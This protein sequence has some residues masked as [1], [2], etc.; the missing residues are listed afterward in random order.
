VTAPR[1]APPAPAGPAPRPQG[2][3]ARLLSRSLSGYLCG[4][5][6]GLLDRRR[7][8]RL[9][10]EAIGRAHARLALDAGSVPLSLGPG[11]WRP[12]P[13]AERL[14][15]ALRDALDVPAVVDLVL[16]G[17]Q[18]RGSVTGYSDVDAILVI[19]DEVAGRPEALRELR[20]RVL[21]AQRHVLGYQPM[22]HHGF[23]LATPSLLRAAGDA[24]ALPAEALAET[25]TL[26]G[27]RLPAAS[28][29]VTADE[30]RRRWQDFAPHLLA[31]RSWPRHPWSLHGAISM[32]ALAPALFAQAAGERGPKWRSFDV[33]RRRFGNAWAPY[34]TL[35]EV[36][37]R[38]PDVG[39][40]VLAPMLRLGANPW[41]AVDAWR[42]LPV[43]APQPARALLTTQTLRDLHA[44]VAMM[45][46]AVE[47]GRS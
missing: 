14:A 28:E 19:E 38:W 39:P 33:G 4:T 41:P 7:G 3:K 37:E 40:G 25:A 47:A 29:P 30:A 32:F 46:A 1:S 6:S 17:S 21:R 42:R 31:L 11:A 12:S 44:V 45:Q 43:R 13:G 2:T 35:R 15:A 34:D 26:F 5:H 20:P 16:Y 10:P 22:Q 23:E 27:R 9:V 18:A 8:E 36:R 24:L